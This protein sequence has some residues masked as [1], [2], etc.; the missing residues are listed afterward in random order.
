MDAAADV[1]PVEPPPSVWKVELYMD[2]VG[3]RVEKRTLIEG[4]GESAYV[5]F[6]QMV[7]QFGDGTAAQSA[8]EFVIPASATVAEAYKGFQV[9]ADAKA[10]EV[11]AGIEREHARRVITLPGRSGR[12]PGRN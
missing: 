6:A 4:S 10:A 7:V 3:R 5:G 12:P 1:K 8:F 9:A 2:N 11:R